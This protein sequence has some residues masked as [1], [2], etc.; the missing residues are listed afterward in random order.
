MLKDLLATTNNNSNEKVR[1][2]INNKED[3]LTSNANPKA[4]RHSLK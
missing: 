1:K 3:I 2:N 4:H